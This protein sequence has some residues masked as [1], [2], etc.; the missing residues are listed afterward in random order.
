MMYLCIVDV[1]LY[2]CWLLFVLSFGPSLEN[3]AR[4]QL[5]VRSLQKLYVG[6][7]VLR[8]VI[9]IQEELSTPLD[10]RYIPR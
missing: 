3:N 9:A 7:Y 10:S 2:C 6:T 4:C 8:Y 5:L 1:E